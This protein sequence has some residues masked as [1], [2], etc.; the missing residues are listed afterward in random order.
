M[1][2]RNSHRKKQ[3]ARRARVPKS[4]P[5]DHSAPPIRNHPKPLLRLVAGVIVTALLTVGKV[6]LEQTR[7][8]EQ[9][10]QMT[11]NLL[12]LRLADAARGGSLRVAVVDMS[13]VVPVAS[14]NDGEPITPRGELKRITRAIADANPAAI[15]MDIIFQP[16]PMGH[17]A[18]EDADFLDFCLSLKGSDGRP[19][20]T[21]VG[22]HESIVRGPQVWLGEKRFAPLGAAVVVPKAEGSEPTLR[23]LSEIRLKG[24]NGEVVATS[25]SSALARAALRS[26]SQRRWLGRRLSRHLPWMIEDEVV[27]RQQALEAR[28]FFVDFS[29]TARLMA[30]AVRVKSARDLTDKTAALSGRVVLVSAAGKPSDQFDVPGQGSP[31][32]G[33]YV[34][35]AA[36]NTLLDAPLYK[37]TD[38]GRVVADVLATMIP[39]GIIFAFEWSRRKRDVAEAAAERLFRS[40]ALG[41]AA[42]IVVFGYFWIDWT[43]VLWTDFLMVIGAL[44]L[45]APAERLVDRGVERLESRRRV[46]T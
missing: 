12:Q 11:M 16:D 32:P 27:K 2:P 20:P 39:L 24:D 43:G 3:P 14:G 37:L 22:I 30:A 23:V 6:G 35:A 31:V 33:V 44:L 10:E 42:V 41:M 21:F 36:V 17:L 19:V 29:G 18:P 15:G 40:L 9:I 26:E 28:E 5:K 34:H 45:H 13:H 1:A 38:V 25:L 7:F 4:V 8:G 46:R